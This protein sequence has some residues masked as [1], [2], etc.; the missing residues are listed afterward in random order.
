METFCSNTVTM[1]FASGFH[2]TEV[3]GIVWMHKGPLLD[4]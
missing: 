3:D 2:A 1:L 4:I